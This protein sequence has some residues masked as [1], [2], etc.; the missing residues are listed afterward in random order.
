MAGYYVFVKRSLICGILILLFSITAVAE[1]A[2]IHITV[3][4]FRGTIDVLDPELR[5]DLAKDKMTVLHF[6]T[7]G[8]ASYTMDIAKPTYLVLYFLS[9]KFFNYS[10]FLSP[11][12]ELFIA[13]DFGRKNNNIVITGRGSNNNQPEIFALTNMDTERFK[14]EATPDNII[15]AINKQFLLNKLL[16]AN[17]IKVNKP[18][19]GFIKIAT[20]NLQYFA[21][22]TY[23]EFYRNNYFG[24]P[25]EQLLKWQRIQDSLFST[26]KLSNGGALTAYNYAHLIDN[27]MMRETEKLLLE[28]KANPVLFNKQWFHSGALKEKKLFDD[29]KVGVVI[30]KIIGKYFTGQA[31][32][33]AYCQALKFVFHKADYPST[34]LLFDDFK[35]KYPSSVYIKGF[36]APLAEVFNKQRQALNSKSI[37]VA[38]NGT[39]LNTF[40]DVLALMKGKTV[41]IDMWGT[42]CG[43]CREEMQKNAEQLR[44]YFTGK[45]ITFLYIANHDIG[46]EK[47][48]K[49]LIAFFQIEGL[50]ILANP[51]LTGDI[52][53]KVKASGYPTYIIVKKDGSYKQSTTKYP[54]NV[55]AMIKEIEAAAT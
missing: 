24:K 8:S 16:L 51:K 23:Y 29:A 18:S 31:A 25:K 22:V 50:H 6:D 3:K 15:A 19:A 10:L 34:V 52:M 38:D 20:S 21:P 42:W 14:G 17:Y 27:F 35:K 45:N 53:G 11:G 48:W 13:T 4:N 49:K 41:F 1:R 37:F 47:E 2:T 54:V 5:Y 39:K 55:Q 40:K 28:Y 9:S 26:I 30:K 46:K 12:D 33:Y 36:S 7:H 44:A 43:P 32:E